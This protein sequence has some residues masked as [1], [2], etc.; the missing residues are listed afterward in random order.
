MWPLMLLLIFA[1]SLLLAQS[2]PA[3]QD[4]SPHSTQ[5]VTVAEQLQLEVLYWGGEGPPLVLLAGLG[6]T[7]HVFDDLA[8][9]LTSRFHVYGI[10][11]RGFGASSWPE[12][13]YAVE[14]LRDDVLAVLDALGLQQVILAGHSIGGQELSAMAAAYPQRVRALIYLDAAYQYAFDTDG[15]Q[16]RVR[17][18]KAMPEFVRKVFMELAP[19]FPPPPLPPQMPMISLAAMDTLS[20]YRQAQARNHGFAMP[21]GELA[22]SLRVNPQGQIGGVRPSAARDAGLAII[23]GGRAFRSIPGPVLALFAY[24]GGREP[25]MAQQTPQARL[26]LRR[27][28]SQKIMQTGAHIKAFGE[29]VPQARVVILPTAHH[30]LFITHQEEVVREMT[31]FLESLNQ[32]APGLRRGL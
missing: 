7:A 16:A 21:E 32:E 1:P 23:E 24:P 14:Q 8:P 25:W 29:G 10:T 30:F 31:D 3:W 13:G 18:W 28:F 4:P 5:F 20:Q 26:L 19:E 12:S 2:P 15:M 27:Q 11:R 17:S 9:A 22:M 6:N